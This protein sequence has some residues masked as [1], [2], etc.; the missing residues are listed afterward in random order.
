[1]KL[2]QHTVTIP[3]ADYQELMQAKANAEQRFVEFKFGLVGRL[4]TLEARGFEL[5]RMSARDFIHEIV[6]QIE[7]TT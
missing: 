1:M 4:K 5:S 2:D 7:Q 3:I 6:R